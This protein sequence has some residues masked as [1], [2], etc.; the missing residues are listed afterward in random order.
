MVVQTFLESPVTRPQHWP[1]P[2]IA[3]PVC[4][5][6]LTSFG[7][8]H[9]D[10]DVV[11]GSY[12]GQRRELDGT[13]P[14]VPCEG[15][16]RLKLRLIAGDGRD[17]EREDTECQSLYDVL[18]LLILRSHAFTV[19]IGREKPTDRSLRLRKYLRS[20]FKRMFCQKST[21]VDPD[22]RCQPLHR[23]EGQ[24][25]L[26]PLDATHVGAVNSDK[27]GEVFLAESA[28]FAVAA[29][30]ATKGLL[31][32]AFHVFERSAVLLE[33]LHTYE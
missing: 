30:V 28:L 31:Q 7:A 3:G 23:T 22:H 8:T 10:P 2:P 27:V 18:D 6:A 4:L 29:E 24:I 12:S 16:R 26:S 25:A 5:R 17:V 20:L 1:T 32:V 14:S 9:S 15:E 19:H 11:G 21:R 33:G 13:F